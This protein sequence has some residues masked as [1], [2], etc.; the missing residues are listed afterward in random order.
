MEI[1]SLMLIRHIQDLNKCVTD[2]YDDDDEEKKIS[3]VGLQSTK[4]GQQEG[5]EKNNTQTLR[6]DLQSYIDIR[7]YFFSSFLFFSRFTLPSIVGSNVSARLKS[8]KELCDDNVPSSSSS[9][10]VGVS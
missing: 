10:G 2:D 1:Q 6:K 8:D 9:C 7:K 5:T 3:L 4:Q